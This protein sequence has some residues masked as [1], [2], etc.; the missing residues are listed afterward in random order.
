[1]KKMISASLMCADLLD[2]RGSIRAL[3]DAGADWLH[4]DV[5]DGHFVPNWMMFPDLVNAVAR[6][7]RL[8]LDVHLMVEEPLAMLPRLKLRPG[9]I[10]TISL[11]STRHVHR[12]L[13]AVR[14]MC[15]V[16][17]LALNPG[18]PL[19]MAEELYPDFDHLMLMTV[20]PGFAGQ[21]LVPQS[22][23][24]IARARAL[25]DERGFAATRLAVDGNCS[26]DNVPLMAR[27]GADT[28]VAGSSSL[29]TPDL[30][31]KEGARRLRRAMEG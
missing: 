12:A 25:L 4:C 9:D 2:L 29:F 26:F 23:D 20:N 27:A 30:G 31:L 22:L 14:G 16:P 15:C 10:L 18:T 1:M 5:M 28:F 11:E 24:K 13:A 7:T 21:K 6:E 8:P 17:G 19:C 3:E